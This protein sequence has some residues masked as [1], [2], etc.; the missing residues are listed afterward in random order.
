MWHHL[1]AWHPRQCISH[2]LPCRNNNKIPKITKILTK[3]TEIIEIET[4]IEKGTDLGIE[5]VIEVTEGE[6]LDLGIAK[7]GD[8]I[9][10]GIGIKT[11][12]LLAV[13]LEVS[14]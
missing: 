11:L 7:I 5:I 1:W 8:G 3:K 12:D 10:P 9:D 13:K 2:P 14:C 6:D 4:E